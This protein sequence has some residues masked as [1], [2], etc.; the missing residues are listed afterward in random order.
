MRAKYKEGALAWAA[1]KFTEGGYCTLYSEGA[2]L[3]GR[4]GVDDKIAAACRKVYD[5]ELGHVLNGIVAVNTHAREVEDWDLLE[6]L[7]IEQLR[8]R[9]V[10]RNAQFSNPV[11]QSRVEEIYAG[12][13]EP[14]RVDL[15]GIMAHAA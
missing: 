2:N 9:V 7:V 5:D 10:M 11:P 3:K 4:G 1:L 13:I 14:I 15:D 6:K 8:R 12:K